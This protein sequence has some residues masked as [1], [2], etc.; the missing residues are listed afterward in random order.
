MPITIGLVIIWIVFFAGLFYS[1]R[2]FNLSA[3]KGGAR[4][5]A[6][7][8]ASKEKTK[9]LNHK[10]KIIFDFDGKEYS[11]N[12]WDAG[13]LIFKMGELDPGQKITVC[14]NPKNPAKAMAGSLK[15]NRFWWGLAFSFL[16]IIIPASII[17]T[18]I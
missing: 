1:A 16:I 4:E 18:L 8:V 14:F 6:G 5:A 13:G 9:N 12:T 10:Y 3:L 11:F 17:A 15:R 2:G 7:S